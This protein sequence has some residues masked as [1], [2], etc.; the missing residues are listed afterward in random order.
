MTNE[1]ITLEEAKHITVTNILIKLLLV[2][3]S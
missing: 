1:Q 3:I 2:N